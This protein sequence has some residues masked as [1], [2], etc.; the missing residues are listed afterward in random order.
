MCEPHEP[1]EPKPCKKY[2]DSI[3]ILKKIH[4]SKGSRERTPNNNKNN[5]KQLTK[6]QKAHTYYQ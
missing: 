5:M 1:R 2:T 6:W 4:K 3:Q